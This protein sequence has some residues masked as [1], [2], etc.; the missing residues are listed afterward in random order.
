MIFIA[1]RVEIN[2]SSIANDSSISIQWL[3][4]KIHFNSALFAFNLGGNDRFLA[5]QA[6][7]SLPA[8]NDQTISFA[9]F[10]RVKPLYMVIW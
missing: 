3:W 8:L 4:K 10:V 9:K 5:V 1:K 7:L 6:L 2:T